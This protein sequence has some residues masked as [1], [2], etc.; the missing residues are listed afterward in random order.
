ME[1]IPVDT[2]VRG[3]EGHYDVGQ[4]LGGS[5]VDGG[6]NDVVR[7]RTS[8]GLYVA[9]MY[10]T[11]RYDMPDSTSLEAV[12]QLLIHLDHEG[13]GVETPVTCSEGPTVTKLESDSGDRWISVYDWVEGATCSPDDTQQGTLIGRSLARLHDAGKEL[14]P[15]SSRPTMDLETMTLAPF[16]YLSAICRS[17]SAAPTANRNLSVTVGR[18]YAGTQRRDQ[19]TLCTAGTLSSI[20]CRTS[21]AVCSILPL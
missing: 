6:R 4:V 12:N 3:V 13:V 19:R 11:A 1:R 20:C 2:V 16:T 15:L 8:T 18:V 21:R 10:A 7:L 17:D 14:L 9:K 5:R